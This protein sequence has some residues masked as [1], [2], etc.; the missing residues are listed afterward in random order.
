MF[1]Q[2]LKKHASDIVYT[3][4]Q[5]TKPI[6]VRSGRSSDKGKIAFSWDAFGVLAP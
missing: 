1:S 2:R 5:Q 6:A 3:Y 4:L